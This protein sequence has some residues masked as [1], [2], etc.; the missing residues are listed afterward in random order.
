MKRAH[1]VEAI[2]LS[3]RLDELERTL[4]ASYGHIEVT[5]VCGKTYCRHFTQTDSGLGAAVFQALQD[6]VRAETAQVEAQ[7]RELGVEV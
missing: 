4:V 1:L 5:T 3:R 6:D 7:L 2:T